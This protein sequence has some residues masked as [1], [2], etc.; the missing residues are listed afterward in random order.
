MSIHR[1]YFN[2]SNTILYDSY[3][4]T[5]R[6]PIVELFYGRLANVGVPFGHSRYIF[7]IDITQLQSKI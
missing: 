4:N 5:S 1:S 2:K 3:T 7:N 6:N